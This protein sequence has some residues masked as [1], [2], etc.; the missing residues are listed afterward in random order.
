MD[1][2]RGKS[3]YRLL[4]QGIFVPKEDLPILVRAYYILTGEQ[5]DVLGDTLKNG[6]RTVNPNEKVGVKLNLEDVRKY[7]Q[8]WEQVSKLKENNG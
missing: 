7:D 3:I 8:F 1:S 6:V 5:L 4:Q 2:E